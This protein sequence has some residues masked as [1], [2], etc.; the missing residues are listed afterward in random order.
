MYAGLV[1]F[2]AGVWLLQ[3]QPELPPA[4]WLWL[5]PLATCVGLLPRFAHPVAALLRRAL[6]ALVC[7]ALGFAYAAWRADL[8][9]D[10]RLPAY[11]QGVDIELVGVVTGLPQADARGERFRFDVERVLTPGAPTIGRVQ[12]GFYYP[13]DAVKPDHAASSRITPAPIK[14]APTNPNQPTA[15]QIAST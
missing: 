13:R 6:I 5:L 10:T 7:V 2:C 3:L 15:K 9:L 14:P 8:R 1:A 12:L 4:R 11:W